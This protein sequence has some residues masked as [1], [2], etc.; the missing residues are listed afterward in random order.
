MGEAPILGSPG[1]GSDDDRPEPHRQE[2]RSLRRWAVVVIAILTAT[3]LGSVL[4]ILALLEGARS[5]NLRSLAIVSILG[6]LVG[7]SAAM[8]GQTMEALTVGWQLT[9]GTLMTIGGRPRPRPQKRHSG[10]T[11]QPRVSPPPA[12]S[13]IVEAG[14]H[15]AR[16]EDNREG[17]N[18]QEGRRSLTRP[19]TDEEDSSSVEPDAHQESDY[20]SLGIVVL[21][22]MLPLI[23]GSL[24]IAVFSGVVGGFIVASGGSEQNLS[25]PGLLFLAFIAGFFAPTFIQRLSDVS[26]ALFGKRDGIGGRQP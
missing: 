17:S 14:P 15:D 25:V 6:S 2:L 9:D 26:D 18:E 21:A 16:I 5:S 3:V 23:A 1:S 13:R 11:T 12:S 10:G 4:G 19:G 8:L 7:G 24:G 20:F 22:L